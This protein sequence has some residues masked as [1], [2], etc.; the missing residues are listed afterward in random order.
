MEGL[1]GARHLCSVKDDEGRSQLPGRE[2]HAEGSGGPD[3]EN[4]RGWANVVYGVER[5]RKFGRI[6][7]IHRGVEGGRPAGRHTSRRM[8]GSLQK[9]RGRI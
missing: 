8:H 6:G 5:G 4:E 3:K 2:G 7:S 1:L 9:G